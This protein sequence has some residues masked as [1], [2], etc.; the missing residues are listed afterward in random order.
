MLEVRTRENE[1]RFLAMTNLIERAKEAL[2]VLGHDEWIFDPENV[3]KCPHWCWQL[4]TDFSGTPIYVVCESRS[5]REHAINE[6][7]ALAVAS[8]PDLARAVLAAEELAK[9]VRTEI[10]V[11]EDPSSSAG[12]CLNA[13]LATD[14]ALTAYRQTTGGG[15]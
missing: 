5:R 8:L 9:A 1:G 14:A 4:R 12:E 13:A 7:I 11:G 2:E 15:S 10:K 6:Q 3:E